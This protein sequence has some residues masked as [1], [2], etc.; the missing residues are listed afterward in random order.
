VLTSIR[1]VARKDFRSRYFSSDQAEHQQADSPDIFYQFN[2]RGFRDTE[3]P[4]DC[5][6]A[7]WCIGDSET[8]GT[9]V[10]QDQTWPA[11]LCQLLDR[12]TINISMQKA[13][14]YWIERQ[15]QLLFEEIVNSDLVIQWSFIARSELSLIEA[16]HQE[17]INL[18]ATIKEPKWPEIKSFEDFTR[19]DTAIQQAVT[20]DLYYAEISAMTNP[21]E[22]A[23]LHFNP[24]LLL[25]LN[26]ANKLIEFV[27]AVEQARGTNRI[28]HAVVPQFA[29]ADE[30]EYIYRKLDLLGI[31]YIPEYIAIDYGRDGRHSGPATFKM[32]AETVINSMISK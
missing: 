6:N 13:S 28:V 18:Y 15:C 29:D 26:G 19:L 32:F 23:Q 10:A 20:A 9:G 8:L 24:D 27:T 5:G 31:N 4:A 3:W 16:K 1:N 17:L 14:N 11:Q 30:C 7:V 2:S 22:S 21:G 12:P 25:D